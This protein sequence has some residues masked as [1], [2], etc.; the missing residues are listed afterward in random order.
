MSGWR[1]VADRLGRGEWTVVALVVAAGVVLR[2]VAASPLWLD[3]ALSV[4]IAAG[5]L[6]DIP[7]ALRRDGHPPLYYALLN[8]WIRLF[9]E[10]DV[11]VRSLSTLFGLAAL[12]AVAWVAWRRGGPRLAAPAA[13]FMAVS[14]FA[15]RYSSEARMYSLLSL[16]VALGWVGLERA[17]ERPTFRRLVPVAAV[18]AAL[19]LTHYWS[20]YL[21][22]VVGAWLLWRAWSQPDDRARA[23]PTAGAI[24]IGGLA[25]VPWLPVFLYQA[26][27][28]GTPWATP[29]RP[30]TVVA[31]SLSAF[32]GPPTPESLLLFGVWSVLWVVAV[33]GHDGGRRSGDTAAGGSRGWRLVLSAPPWVWAA[34]AAGVVVATLVV[35]SLAGL[36]TDSA[37]QSRYAAVVLPPAIVLAGAGAARIEVTWVRVLTVLVVAGLGLAGVVEDL[38]N[39]R[40]QA[41]VIAAAIE[42][43]A[44]LGDVVVYCPDQLGPA[45][46]RLVAPLG[47]AEVTYPEL[48]DPAR[49]DWVDYAERHRRADP[50]AFAAEVE[51]LTAPGSAVWVVWNDSYRAVGSQCS[52][53]VEALGRNRPDV[54]VVVAADP[55]RYFEH[56]NLFRFAPV[57]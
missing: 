30:T 10:G 19:L 26:G 23:L 32:A 13:A 51:A 4:D 17:W 14:P 42:S 7:D 53:I 11:A 15:V 2:F 52:G 37:F 12:A 48:A 33:F 40:S 28:T 20:F 22:G 21:L 9:G 25:F 36:V 24:A 47:L 18:S 29:S 1:V 44:R 27:H 55:E 5:P 8:G 54:E 45:T 50:A 56:A 16:L 41:G 46:H 3:E 31:D 38:R 34:R 57:S 49:V 39:D 43:G 35:G 6:A